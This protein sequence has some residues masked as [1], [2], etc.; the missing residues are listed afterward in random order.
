MNES[1]HFKKVLDTIK[2][3]FTYLPVNSPNIVG[4]L[5]CIKIY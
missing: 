5:R 3:D 2:E 1:D 4:V